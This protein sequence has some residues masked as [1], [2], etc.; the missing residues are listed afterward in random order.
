MVG[1]R[2]GVGAGRRLRTR[3]HARALARPTVSRP[4]RA[5][6]HAHAGRAQQPADAGFQVQHGAVIDRRS[7]GGSRHAP[8]MHQ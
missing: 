1:E 7:N 3:T 6:M 2:G 5:C 4:A 8:A